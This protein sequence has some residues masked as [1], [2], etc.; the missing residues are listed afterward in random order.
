[1]HGHSE[2]ARARA[3]VSR[4]VH[5]HPTAFGGCAWALVLLHCQ[6]NFPALSGCRCFQKG[7]GA[8]KQFYVLFCALMPVASF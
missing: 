1:M 3:Q 5:G 4:W 7:E 8:T 2:K 6:I